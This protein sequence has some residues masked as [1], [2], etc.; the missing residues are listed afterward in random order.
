[1]NNNRSDL[2]GR[3]A[4][5]LRTFMTDLADTDLFSGSVLLAKNNVSVFDGAYGYANKDFKVPNQIDT[6][7]N[8]GSINKMF[9]AVAVLQLVEQDSLLLDDSLSKF[10]PNFP[11]TA[12]AE[13]I[14]ISHLLS[15]TAGLGGYFTKRYKEASRDLLRSVDDMIKLAAADERL[16]FEPGTRYQYSNT[17]MLVLGKVIE[18]ISGKSYFDYIRQNIYQP[19]QMMSTDCYELDQVNANLAVGYDRQVTERGTGFRN[20]IFT[21]VIMGGPHGGGYSTV[22]D[23]LK[24]SLALQSNV[25]L[26]QESVQRLLS[27]KPGINSPLNECGILVQRE[28]LI[29]NYSGGFMGISTNIDMFLEAGWTAIVLSNYTSAREP[30]VKKMRELVTADELSF[31]S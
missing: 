26:K 28:P 21:H 29:A 3:I 24:F 4:T 6:K 12:A 23:L 25:F 14:Q 10:V 7:F 8:L 9:T 19:A 15:H 16:L 22:G 13:K 27:S 17:G 5:D 30:V 1:M 2:T 20:N 18:V 31:Q 11:D